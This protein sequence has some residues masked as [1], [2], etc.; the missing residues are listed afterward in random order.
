MIAF[1]D[2]GARLQRRRHRRR[3]HAAGARRARRRRAAARLEQREGG[4]WQ[5]S[6]ER[7]L[8]AGA[9]ARSATPPMLADGTRDLALQ[10]A[11]HASTGSRFDGL[12]HA[13]PRTGRPPTPLERSL[14]ILFDAA[15]RLRARGARR[16]RGARG[17]GEEQLEAVSFR[18]EPLEPSAIERPRLS[19]TYDARR[20]ADPRRHR[21]VGDRRGR[22]RDADRRRGARPRRARPP[23][24][25][26]H[27]AVAFLG[28]HGRGPAP[29]P[30]ATPSRPPRRRAAQF[31][32][33]SR[34]QR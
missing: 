8:R 30:A 28:W 25:R 15:A 9:R 33:P 12:G 31:V 21:A 26:A 17:H 19:T 1:A 6:D 20:A 4:A 14:S 10:S 29:A 18:G 23:R 13:Q 16:P 22:V 24:R 3:R 2:A 27:G 11:R 7:R 5:L 34:S 32:V